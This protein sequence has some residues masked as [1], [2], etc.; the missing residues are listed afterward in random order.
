MINIM[1]VQ[2]RKSRKFSEKAHIEEILSECVH[3]FPHHEV[4]GHPKPL[5]YKVHGQP[6][7]LVVTDESSWSARNH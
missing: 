1:Q 5:V 2:N 7:P 6:K 4:C 3:W